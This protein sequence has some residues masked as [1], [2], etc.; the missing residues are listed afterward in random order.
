MSGEHTSTTTTVDAGAIAGDA[1]R[2]LGEAW[3]RA[4]G[5]A[6]GELF[7]DDADFVDIR[8]AH[9]HGAIAIGAGHQAI[10]DT[11]YAGSS[12]AYRVE[13]ARTIRPGCVLALVAATLDAPGGPLRGV[14]RS[15]ITAVLTDEHDRWTIA[16]FQNTLVQD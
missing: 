3:N 4:D 1:F 2:E 14:N 7:A 15:R 8:G 10:L 9:H 16:A 5:A 6:F 11:I 13:V 12:V